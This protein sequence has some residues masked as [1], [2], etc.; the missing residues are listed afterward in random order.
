MEHI[1]YTII[2][3]DDDALVDIRSTLNDCIFNILCGKCSLKGNF[4]L[5]NSNCRIKLDGNK[6][7]MNSIKINNMKTYSIVANEGS[8]LTIMNTEIISAGEIG[9]KFIFCINS[10]AIGNKIYNSKIGIYHPGYP[11]YIIDRNEIYIL[12]MQFI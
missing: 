9:I 5:R 8:F 3:I 12:Q 1:W 11:T 10:K 2:F 7:I 6:S 4:I